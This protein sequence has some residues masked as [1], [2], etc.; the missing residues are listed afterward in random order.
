M[1]RMQ[2]RRF[3]THTHTYLIMRT[4]TDNRTQPTLRI[5]GKRNFQEANRCS[6]STAA[7]SRM[8]GAPATHPQLRRHRSTARRAPARS[9]HRL[10]SLHGAQC[11]LPLRRKDAVALSPDIRRGPFRSRQGHTGLCAS[12]DR[13]HTRRDTPASGT[14]NERLQKSEKQL[15]CHGQGAQQGGRTG[16]AAQQDVHHIGQQH[17]YRHPA[18]YHGFQR[19]GNHL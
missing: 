14:T 10:R 15:Q 9:A 19:N 18:E 7:R 4:E 13:A 5:A 16:D 3:L 1:Q 6:L 2:Y 12:A 11:S 8:A 17:R